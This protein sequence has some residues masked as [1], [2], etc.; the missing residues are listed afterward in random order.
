MR[1]KPLGGI[2]KKRLPQHTAE[3][4]F[5]SC[6]AALL[7]LGCGASLHAWSTEEETLMA[8]LGREE[9]QDTLEKVTSSLI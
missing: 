5:A 1:E 4:G 2:P 8:R 7:S 6:L 3:A 9:Q